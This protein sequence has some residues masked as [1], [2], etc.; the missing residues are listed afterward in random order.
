[1]FRI[2]DLFKSTIVSVGVQ[3]ATR[4]ASEAP[5][6][7]WDQRDEVNPAGWSQ[8]ESIDYS[9]LYALGWEPIYRDWN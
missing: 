3:E 7:Y 6:P 8:P 9:D 4:I 2:A 1:M 5:R